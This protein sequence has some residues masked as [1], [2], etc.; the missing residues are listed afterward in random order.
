MTVASIV[1]AVQNRIIDAPSNV[2]GEIQ[3]LV[4]RAHR[5]IQELHNFSTMER[6]ESRTTTVGDPSLGTIDAAAGEGVSGSPG[7]N[8]KS[9]KRDEPPFWTDDNGYTRT[10]EVSFNEVEVRRRFSQDTTL[11]R[12]QPQVLLHRHGATYTDEPGAV[13]WKVYPVPDGLAQTSDGEYSIQ[14]PFWRYAN[15]PASF[16]WFTAH[17]EEF[18][19]NYA[20]AEA[21]ALLRDPG[22]YLFWRQKAV[23]PRW[24]SEGVMGG[25]LLRVV[26]T[27]KA[28]KTSAIRTLVPYAGARALTVGKRR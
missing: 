28:V 8:F 20:T 12:G 2:S 26:R 23:G 4:E 15:F 10:L 9:Y 6:R 1:T 25:D 22:N 27:D 5:Q 16:D 18:L 7:D 13:E 19:I 14:I 11:G 21:F 3:T 17:A 24:D